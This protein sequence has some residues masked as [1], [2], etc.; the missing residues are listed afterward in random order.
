MPFSF[1]THR[2][3]PKTTKEENEV[4]ERS[5]PNGGSSHHEKSHSATT[6]LPVPLILPSPRH[7]LDPNLPD[8]ISIQSIPSRTSISP[9]LDPEKVSDTP[10]D[11]SLNSPYPQVRAA[12]RNT[13]LCLSLRE[14]GLKETNLNLSY[15]VHIEV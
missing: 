7:S 2:S 14:T 12:V 8:P 1:L 6:S 15:E 3:K 11:I 5:T 9:D 10:I 13:A 4:D